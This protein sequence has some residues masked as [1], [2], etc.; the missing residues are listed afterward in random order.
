MFEEQL[1]EVL[2]NI[3]VACQV[4]QHHILLQH[5]HGFEHDW[6]LAILHVC[7]GV[8]MRLVD[9]GDRWSVECIGQSN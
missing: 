2:E 5:Q 8:L 1:R 9:N 4:K 6:S 3:G 7:G